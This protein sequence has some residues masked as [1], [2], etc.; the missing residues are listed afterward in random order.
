[1]L[2]DPFSTVSRRTQ[3][4]KSASSLRSI[5]K[6]GQYAGFTDRSTAQNSAVTAAELAFERAKWMSTYEN[7]HLEPLKRVF[8]SDESVNHSLDRRKSI[9][10]TGPFATTMRQHPKLPRTADSHPGFRWRLDQSSTHSRQINDLYRSGN[11]VDSEFDVDTSN[12]GSSNPQM[13]TVLRPELRMARSMLTISK[14]NPSRAGLHLQR[15]SLRSS[16]G[17]SDC[18]PIRDR[19]VSSAVHKN[20][21]MAAGVAVHRDRSSI[22]NEAIQLAHDDYLRQTQDK[23][24][25]PRRSI[26]GLMKKDRSRKQVAGV[27]QNRNEAADAINVSTDGSSLTSLGSRARYLSRSITNK[28]KRAFQKS[29]VAFSEIPSQHLQAVHPHFVRRRS[30]SQDPLLEYPLDPSPNL[31]LLQREELRVSKPMQSFSC[32]ERTRPG[33]AMTFSSQSHPNS[34][35]SRITSWTDSTVVCPVSPAIQL[36]CKRLSVI[37]E[38]LGLPQQS[39][40]LNET[41]RSLNKNY[42]HRQLP[43]ETATGAIEP[44]RVYSALQK[45]IE[46]RSPQNHA[47]LVEQN[48]GHEFTGWHGDERSASNRSS[49]PDKASCKNW[50]GG[51]S[52]SRSVDSTFPKTNHL[53][54]ST[55]HTNTKGILYETGS[56]LFP[57]SL[58]IEYAK[59]SSPY[60]RARQNLL[61]DGNFSKITLAGSIKTETPCE[62]A[63]NVTPS[64]L[65]GKSENFYPLSDSSQKTGTDE[66]PPFVESSRGSPISREIIARQ[67]N[68]LNDAHKLLHQRPSQISFQTYGSSPEN[69]PLSFDNVDNSGTRTTQEQQLADHSQHKGLRHKREC[70]QIWSS[71]E[72]LQSRKTSPARSDSVESHVVRNQ[73]ESTSLGSIRASHTFDREPLFDITPTHNNRPSHPRTSLTNTSLHRIRMTSNDSRVGSPERRQNPLPG[74]LAE[75]EP[76]YTSP[77]SSACRDSPGRKERMRRLNTKSSGSLPWMMRGSARHSD[78]KGTSTAKWGKGGTRTEHNLGE[79]VRKNSD[80]IL[81]GNPYGSANLFDKTHLVEDYLRDKRRDGAGE[82]E[83]SAK[84]RAFL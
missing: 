73:I 21:G 56:A 26:L 68:Q 41:L 70:A 63:E 64:L 29:P 53:A 11:A 52:S 22:N 25:K 54:Q 3:R 60:R 43:Q 74:S 51:L 1:M 59:G 7:A 35:H 2:S 31:E 27:Q 34:D 32:G 55:E 19:S 50:H 10:F 20:H 38:D 84:S 14:T 77:C 48:T 82:I 80:G 17:S 62:D 16:E 49:T 75:L 47:K 24:L 79:Q 28:V 78:E 71:T 69:K 42:P 72:S 40:S 8:R 57:S 13:R 66:S 30:V 67:T 58:R 81:G 46:K 37:M 44:R 4:S 45:E 9:R 65:R 61:C 36:D 5:C 6:D 39:R 83:S 76:E 23:R 33:S 12:K 18:D 15:Q